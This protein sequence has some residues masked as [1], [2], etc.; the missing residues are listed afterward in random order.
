MHTRYTHEKHLCADA[1]VVQDA[2]NLSA[3]LGAMRD[4]AVFLNKAGLDTDAIRAHPAMVMFGSKV[5]HLTGIQADEGTKFAEARVAASM[6][7]DIGAEGDFLTTEDARPSLLAWRS[8]APHYRVAEIGDYDAGDGA[9]F[10]LEHQ[11]SCYRRGPHKLILEI[12]SGKRHHWWGCF[13]DAD[14][15]LR[16]YHDVAV[17][18]SEAQRIAD[19]LWA[20]R[21]KHSPL[22]GEK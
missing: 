8:K 21:I 9:R 16:W 18:Q 5:A 1:I 17:A 6:K 13:D 7:L 11:P 10:H 15:P 12:A 4:G 20:D 2:C 22:P 3:V 19:V 14:A